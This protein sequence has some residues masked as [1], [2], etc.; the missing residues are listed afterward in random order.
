[1]ARMEKAYDFEKLK[2]PNCL[3]FNSD[4]LGVPQS[5]NYNAMFLKEMT[6]YLFKTHWAGYLNGVYFRRYRVNQRLDRRWPAGF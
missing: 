1:M 3:K 5:S 4:F 2:S 6:V